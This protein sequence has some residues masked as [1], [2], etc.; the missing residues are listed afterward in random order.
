MSDDI[1]SD[2]PNLKVL[3]HHREYFN[4][5][6]EFA[7]KIGKFEPGEEKPYQSLLS[8][9]KYLNEWGG[10]G[11]QVELYPDSP[12]GFGFLIQRGSEGNWRTIFNG[13]LLYHGQHD[14]FGSGMG[15]T[16]AVTLGATD[17]WSIH[18]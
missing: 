7:K 13:G 6:V 2:F 1:L 4:S 18:T 12:Y 3:E 10:P 8:N 15:P 17:G 9:L 16:F 5:V 14:G 11:H